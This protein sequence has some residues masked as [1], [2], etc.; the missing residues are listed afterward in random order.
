MFPMAETTAVATR[1]QF[2]WVRSFR[3]L[4]TLRFLCT[5]VPRGKGL[6]LKVICA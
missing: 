4:L 6:H 2:L 5:F 3:I 1:G